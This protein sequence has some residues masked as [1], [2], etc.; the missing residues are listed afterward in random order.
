MAP[1]NRSWQNNV[2][3]VGPKG[4]RLLPASSVKRFVAL[5]VIVAGNLLGCG[6]AAQSR[7]GQ[8]ASTTD[9]ATVM[10]VDPLVASQRLA[11]SGAHAVDI[12]LAKPTIPVKQ[13]TT[14]VGA[15]EAADFSASSSTIGKATRPQLAEDPSERCKA[16]GS[17]GFSQTTDAVV[18]VI[19]AT[20]AGSTPTICEV[21][22]YVAPNIGFLLRFPIDH[23]NGK[24]LEIGCGGACGNTEQIQQCDDPLHRGYACIVSDGGHISS[25]LDLKWAYNNPQAYTDLFVRASHVTALAGK[26]IVTHYFARSPALS[27]FMGCSA[28]GNQA[29]S[30]AERFPWDFDG[31]IAGAPVLS[32]SGLWL[33]VAWGNR[34]LMGKDGNPVLGELDLALL[35]RAVIEE[36]DL[37]DGIKDGLI[38]D[39]RSCRFNPEKLRCREGKTGKCLSGPQLDAIEEIYRGPHTSTGQQIIAPSAQKGSELS[40]L[41]FFGGSE[42]APT[43][44]YRYL[45]EPF[46]YHLFE[47]NPGPAWKPSDLDFDRDYKRFGVAELTDPGN[48]PDL[49]RFKNAGGKLLV[50]TGWSDV[51]EGVL[52]TVD[53]YETAERVIG[54]RR[55][56]QDFFRLFVVPGMNHCTGGDGPF[57]VDY[58]SYL[59]AWVEKGNP[60]AKLVGSHVKLDDLK[61]GVARG[62][63]ASAQE[64]KRRQTFPLD[65]SAVEFSRPIYPYPATAR[66]SGRGDPTSAAN[67]KIEK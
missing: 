64:L 39:P 20:A 29:M 42:K 46:R 48:N 40:W 28:G 57:A 9:A 10:T 32:I 15:P 25:S 1:A 13:D 26:A 30:S 34:A 27:Y 31:I 58:L 56:T 2:A 36:C 41:D 22:G 52:R 16:L 60:P 67:F 43:P 3:L 33:N 66:Y 44:F 24:F 45:G 6:L 11:S 55:Q 51:A 18:Q 14:S 47:P 19:E 62:D 59:E 50:Y 21:R 5:L 7:P 38:G 53:Y 61:E 65:P 49:R 12:R 17:T 23:W 37:N 4:L 35:H 54:D 63:Q 8:L